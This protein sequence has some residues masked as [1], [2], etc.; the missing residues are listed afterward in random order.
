M[1]CI[2]CNYAGECSLWDNT[3]I[4]FDHIVN[5]CDENGY[6]LVEEDEDPLSSCEDYEE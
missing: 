5:S 4:M 2:H 6:C 3:S 1:S